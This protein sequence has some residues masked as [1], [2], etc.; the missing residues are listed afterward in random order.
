M[1]I[2]EIYKVA[3]LTQCEQ[4]EMI[5]HLEEDEDFYSSTSYEKLYEHFC[6]TG[7]M[8]YEVAKARTEC[9]DVWILEKLEAISES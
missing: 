2:N 9:P 5:R 7:E 3:G 8:P 4:K 1:G 6:F